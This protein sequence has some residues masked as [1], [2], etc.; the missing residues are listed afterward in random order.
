MQEDLVGLQRPPHQ[1]H[2]A[3]VAGS[4]ESTG[5]TSLKGISQSILLDTLDPKQRTEMVATLLGKL[6][7]NELLGLPFAEYLERQAA[8]ERAPSFLDNHPDLKGKLSIHK[9]TEHHSV[10]TSSTTTFIVTAE[11]GTAH[12]LVV[13]AA[14]ES[15]E[16]MNKSGP[17]IIT[18]DRARIDFQYG[19]RA[20]ASFMFDRADHC[21][22]T[23]ALLETTGLATLLTLLA[24]D[25]QLP[26]VYSA[27][28]EHVELE[29]ARLQAQERAELSRTFN[30]AVD[31]A[32]N[33][34]HSKQIGR[35]HV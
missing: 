19:T 10:E 18:E 4:A 21:S 25:L 23:I 2:A 20:S 11:D 16:S 17:T 5:P 7:P 14:S 27:E 32:A 33:P 9:H 3:E 12:E 13:S 22:G 35:A 15:F 24:E 30:D 26:L 1:K 31:A 8:A 6:T 34:Y 28:T 29:R